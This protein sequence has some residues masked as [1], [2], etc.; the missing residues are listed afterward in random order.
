MKKPSC[1]LRLHHM[2]C[3]FIEFD[4]FIPSITSSAVQ[5]TLNNFMALGR[6]NWTRTRETLTRLLSQETSVIRDDK[7]LRSK[8]LIRQVG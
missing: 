3:H 5:A 6:S 1:L 4:W 8:A 7:S 2:T